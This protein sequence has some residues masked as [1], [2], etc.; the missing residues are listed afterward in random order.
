MKPLECRKQL[1]KI[2]FGA[3]QQSQS[4]ISTFLGILLGVDSILEMVDGA[5]STFVQAIDIK[6]FIQE[7]GLKN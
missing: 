7:Y 2:T 1:Y 6:M 5:R 3:L 4:T